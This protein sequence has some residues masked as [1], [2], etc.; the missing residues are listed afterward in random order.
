MG[1]PLLLTAAV[2]VGKHTAETAYNIPE[3]NKHLD[4]INLM[5]YDMHGAWES[6]TG[7]NAN[8][9]ATDEDTQ[10]GGGVGAGEAVQGYPLSV[11]WAVDYWLDHGASPSKLT[12]GI[13]T[14]GRGWKLADPSQNGYNAP[15]AGASTPGVSTK[16]AGYKAFYEIL[17]LLQSGRATRY[18]DNDRQCPY[19]VTDDGEWIGYDDAESL[20]AKVN[21]ARS[22]N[23]VGTMVW[24]LDLDDFAGTY[25]GGNKY[26]LISLLR[27]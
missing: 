26:P 10:L 27:K 25:S 12:L 4:L 21:F 23:L 6:R 16:E 17:E 11:S 22:R 14:Y 8:L 18:Y 15:A 24:A 2:G 20:Q 13:G 1:S 7:C 3:M 9:Y 19:I 5:T